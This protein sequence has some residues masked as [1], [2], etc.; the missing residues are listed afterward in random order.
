MEISI[1]PIVEIQK[2]YRV[3]QINFDAFF[4]AITNS[5]TRLP[6]VTPDP[7]GKFLYIT[8]NLF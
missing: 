7:P 3:Y 5:P 1:N 6:T 2:Y 4:L 8:D